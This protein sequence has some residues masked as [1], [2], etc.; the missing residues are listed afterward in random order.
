M[1][2]IAARAGLRIVIG[3][4]VNYN[5]TYGYLIVTVSYNV[6]YV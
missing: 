5:S 4:N 2:I 6:H 3:N 1:K